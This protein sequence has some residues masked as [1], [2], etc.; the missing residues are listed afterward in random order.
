MPSNHS[1]DNKCPWV[2]GSAGPS[3]ACD[4]C[5]LPLHPAPQ[6][7]LRHPTLAL[8]Q[9]HC[10]GAAS[11]SPR[12]PNLSKMQTPGVHKA[13]LLRLTAPTAAPALGTHFAEVKTEAGGRDSL[14]GATPTIWSHPQ[15][16]HCSQAVRRSGLGQTEM[17]EQAGPGPA[18]CREMGAW[19]SW[20]AGGGT[21]C[22]SVLREGPG[23]GLPWTPLPRARLVLPGVG[24]APPSRASGASS[25]A[26]DQ[27]LR[28]HVS[29]GGS[30]GWGQLPQPGQE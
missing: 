8:A 18:A 28:G 26:E 24:G 9:A 20:R 17:G 25:G 15:W 5:L 10:R 6:T 27:D 29:G 12:S 11:G 19:E 22:A 13:S 30:V 1:H 3:W 14:P 23:K 2:W 4:P 16:G 7:P 21:A